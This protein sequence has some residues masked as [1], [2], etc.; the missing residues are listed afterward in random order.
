MVHTQGP[1]PRRD[2]T[3]GGKGTESAPHPSA[4]P[5]RG[6][7]CRAG[8][9]PVA[10]RSYP[11]L[12]TS[13]VEGLALGVTADR[14]CYTGSLREPFPLLAQSKRPNCQGGAMPP[15]S[16]SGESRDK[17]QCRTLSPKP[18]NA[19]SRAFLPCGG[20]S[21]TLSPKLSLRPSYAKKQ[22]R[23]TVPLRFRLAVLRPIA[24]QGGGL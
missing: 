23:G 20:V 14:R 22:G 18:K 24:P 10:K 2:A 16:T 12:R 6:W 17:A 19:L 4:K 7:R 11:P 13:S 8:A 15:A 21:P 1:P 9:S 3:S 5:P